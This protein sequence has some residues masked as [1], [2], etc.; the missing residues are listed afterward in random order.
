MEPKKAFSIF[1]VTTLL[2]ISIFAAG[3]TDI[4]PEPYI[5]DTATPT[6]TPN[7]TATVTPEPTEVTPT[8]TAVP[9]EYL[10]RITSYMFIPVGDKEIN[11]GDTIK[12]RNFE[13]SKQARYLVNENGIWEEE[14]YL[15]Y[16]RYV[17]HTFNETGEYT[18]YLKGRDT[19][20][21]TITVV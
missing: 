21:L 20:V 6:A 19:K 13:N 15:P 17:S 11:V 12:W 2:A 9:Q 7:A 16:M 3:C 8:S 10:I 4:K 18:F 1:I 14:Q 5:E